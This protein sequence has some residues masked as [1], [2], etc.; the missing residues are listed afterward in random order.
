M[1]NLAFQEVLSIYEEEVKNLTADDIKAKYGSDLEGNP[2]V[3][4]G[5]YGKY[6]DGSLFG[7]WL[8]LTK[9][10]EYEEFIAICRQLHKDE[11]DP[12]L[13]FQDYECFPEQFYSESCMDEDTF[14]SIIEY[15]MLSEDEQE[16]LEDYLELGNEYDIEKFRE[17][18]VGKWDSQ[19]EFA[20]HIIDECYDLEQM[21]G[22]LSQYFDYDSYASDLFMTDY[23][24][25]DN[26]HV[27]RSC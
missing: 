6:N 24:M 23:E 20:E 18:Y 10:Q 1:K 22:S 2:S 17:R 12:E 11:E 8:D 25:G 13:M 7:A 3:Y 4:C 15:S 16:A 21:M 19:Q 5:T 14:D 26:H 27:F 9:F